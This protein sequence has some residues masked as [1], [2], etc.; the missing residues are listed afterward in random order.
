MTRR[1]LVLLSLL[2]AAA[3]TPL[4]AQDPPVPTTYFVVTTGPYGGIYHP[5]GGALCRLYNR[6][7][8]DAPDRCR[9]ISSPGSLANVE[10]LRSGEADFAV[11]QRD[12][13]VA[14][15]D[16]TGP[17]EGRPA[18][19]DLRTVLRAHTEPLTLLARSD[20]G[21]AT[22]DD[23]KGKR[24]AVG[25]AASGQRATT[26]ALL[27]ALGW[28]AAD[29]GA[30]IEG[31]PHAQVDALCDGRAD[32]AILVLGHPNGL[33][34]RATAL[35]NARLLALAG[36]RI[37]A[38]VAGSDSYHT[39]T[40]PGGMYANHPAD[41]PSIGG[42]ALVVTLAVQPEDRV[43]HLTRSVF[44]QAD[45]LSRLHLALSALTAKRLVPTPS[46]LPIHPG[47]ARYLRERGLM[48]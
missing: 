35:C 24:L 29:L 30:L 38:L 14:A 37:D 42:E 5:L 27:A 4:A 1:L 28:S 36:P 32:A 40:I 15:V 7:F 22:L 47:T 9:V 39:A 19:M 13:A 41:V 31:E 12:V 2:W 17:L 44:E 3:S 23:L 8:A 11:V 48:E 25:V 21:I 26:D 16:G 34:Q 46:L 43:Y 20:S 45:L 18:L 10:A 33:V 6:A